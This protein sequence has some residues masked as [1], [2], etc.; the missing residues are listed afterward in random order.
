MSCKASFLRILLE[1]KSNNNNNKTKQN[2]LRAL[3]AP[4]DLGPFFK[5]FYAFVCKKVPGKI[6]DKYME[7][8]EQASGQ[9]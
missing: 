2:K 3:L 8:L 6:T 9:I 5:I 1:K 4:E 7:N